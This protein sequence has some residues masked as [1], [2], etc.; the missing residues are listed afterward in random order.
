MYSGYI[1]SQNVRLC[2][3]EVNPTKSGGNKGCLAT[4]TK[5]SYLRKTVGQKKSLVKRETRKFPENRR[6][7]KEWENLGKTP[8]FP[9]PKSNPNQG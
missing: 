4:R 9:S 3:M 5:G 1:G 6:F 8:E 2:G 7:G